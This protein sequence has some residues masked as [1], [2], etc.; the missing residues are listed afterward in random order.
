MIRWNN[1]DII[2]D[3]T[4]PTKKDYKNAKKW[5]DLFNKKM[6]LHKQPLTPKTRKKIL[7]LCYKMDL[8]ASSKNKI[9]RYKR[10]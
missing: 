10:G 7:K 9:I 3:E 1:I 6:E 2:R 4:Q 5:D 8:L